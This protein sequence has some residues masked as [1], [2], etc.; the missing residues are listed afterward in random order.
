MR[1]ATE[2]DPELAIA[3]RA[4][5][6]LAGD[7]HALSALRTQARDPGSRAT[8]DR[9]ET[10]LKP[11][12]ERAGYRPVSDDEDH[13]CAT[14]GR[15][16]GEVDHMMVRGTT[17]I[18][19]RCLATVARRRHELQT[20]DPRVVCALTGRSL[21]DSRAVYVFNGVAISEE[22]VEHSLGLAEHPT[23]FVLVDGRIVN[24]DLDL[25]PMDAGADLAQAIVERVAKRD[26]NDDGP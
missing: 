7:P 22:V 21:V 8:V 13:T 16:S 5:L 26:P 2:A 23:P 15:R 3:A 14:C 24:L 12:A 9:L 17:A 25:I 11:A 1:W 18:C 10:A 20:D 6:G 4:G 19:D